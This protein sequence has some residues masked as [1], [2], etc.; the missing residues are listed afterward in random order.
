MEFNL[1]DI[2]CEA[3]IGSIQNKIKGPIYVYYKLTNYL[4]NHRRYVNSRSNK[5][6]AGEYLTVDEL[7]DCDPIKK[8]GDL[9]TQQKVSLRRDPN[10]PS[11]RFK[12]D[13]ND[14]AIPCGLVA[15]SF[16]ND[17]FQL[18]KR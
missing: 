9:W 11:R 6:L 13:D 4:Q 15:K 7:S 17:T 12:L 18:F 8:V 3:E 14:P 1:Q 5:Q 2:Y 10:N 16:F